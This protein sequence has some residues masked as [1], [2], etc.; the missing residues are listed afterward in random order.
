MT[1]APEDDR[2]RVLGP[3]PG[4]MGGSMMRPP[5]AWCAGDTMSPS[6]HPAHGLTINWHRMGQMRAGAASISHKTLM[7]D[8]RH[9]RVSA[10]QT[11]KE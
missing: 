5:T 11:V 6:T 4:L 3:R 10:F 1:L 7:V 9:E 8:S 2:G